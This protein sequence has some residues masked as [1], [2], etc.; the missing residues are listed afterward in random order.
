M[1]FIAE[2]G[3]WAKKATSLVAWLFTRIAPVF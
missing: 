1:R 2:A 3:L